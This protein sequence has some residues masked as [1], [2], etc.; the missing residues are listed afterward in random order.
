MSKVNRKNIYM[1]KVNKVR[2]FALDC[3]AVYHQRQTGTMLPTNGIK[4]DLRFFV[5]FFFKS[6]LNFIATTAEMTRE[7]VLEGI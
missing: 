1:H 5:L 6:R 7:G 4:S 2:R 3:A